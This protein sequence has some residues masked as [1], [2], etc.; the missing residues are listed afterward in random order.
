MAI[1]SLGRTPSQ[2]P[3]AA[4]VLFAAEWWKQE[5]EG[6]AWDW[7]PIFKKLSVDADSFPPQLRSEFVARGLSFWQLR[8]LADGKRFI[9]SIAVNGGIPMRL[10]AHGSGP[11]ATVLSQLLKL[12][13]RYRWGP[14]QLLEAATERQIYLPAAYRRAEISELLVQFVEAVL[15]LKEE[16]LL[17]GLS[18]PTA[19][20]DSV[21]PNWR[22]RF[23]IAL[24]SEAAQTLLTGLVREAAAQGSGSARGLFHAERRLLRAGDTTCH[25]IESHVSH[26]SRAAVEDIAGMFGFG[27]TERL[28]RYFSIDLETERRQPCTDG[29]I[30][31]GAEESI[32]SLTAGKLVVKGKAALAEHLL[33]LRGQKGDLGDR[34]T[35]PGGSSLPDE[36]PWLFV[37]GEAGHL[38]FAA[39]GGA[40][41]PHD[42]AWVALPV[43][44]S[45][46][47][48]DPSTAED[49]GELVCT[50]V[51]VRK[52]F[53]L[54]ADTRLRL[55]ELQ[56]RVRL[57]QVS[58]ADQIYQWKGV[59][60]PEARGRSVF[61]DRQYPRLYRCGETALSQVPLSDQEWRRRGTQDVVA[62][63]EATGPVEVRVFDGD[64]LCARH[65]IF[66]LRPDAQIEYLSG[67]TLGTGAV[68]FI[69]WGPIELAIEPH[70]GFCAEVSKSGSAATEIELS[71]AGEPPSE[72]RVRIRWPG[73]VGELL[74]V[75]PY[76]VTGG[77]FLRASGQV[78][79]PDESVSLRDLIGMRL[80][81]F[82]TNPARPNRY[83]LQLSHGKGGRKV[84]SQ[85]PIS[86]DAGGRAEVRL[87]DYQRQIES[88]LGLFD[89]LDATVTASLMVAGHCTTE[90]QVRRYAAT[91]EKDAN[92]VRVS[93]STLALLAPADLART[94]VVASPLAVQ[95]ELL[96]ELPS[97]DS[98][99][100]HVGAWSTCELDPSLAPWL[101]YPA[102]DSAVLFRP[103]VWAA[104]VD[105]EIEAIAGNSPITVDEL[106]SAMS[107]PDAYERWSRLHTVL[108]SMS[109]EFQHA[110]WPQLDSLWQT[111]H[112][113]PLPALD[114]WR[115]LAKQPKAVLSFLLRS[116]LPDAELAEALR[117]F[118][119]ETGWVPELT[120]VA[121]LCEVAGT[122][123]KFWSDQGLAADRCRK[124]FNDELTD[125][126]SLLAHEI[127]SLEPFLDSVVFAATGTAS[128]LLLETARL[129]TVDLLRRLWEGGDSLVNAQLFLVNFD[130]SEWPGRDFV[131]RQALPALLE[132]CPDSLTGTLLKHMDKL[133]WNFGA[134]RAYYARD[135]SSSAQPDFKFSAANLPVLCALWSATSTSR[136][137]WGDPHQ[138]LV[139][140]QIRD[141]D[142]VW[143]EQAYHHACKVLMSIDGLV[144]LGRITDQ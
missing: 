41:L 104:P 107:E 100:V 6:G 85:F 128:T 137:W 113:L 46:E 84:S 121:D 43:D 90:I 127:P 125:R 110:S 76:P 1:R 57:K 141:F 28:P 67:E 95:G 99:S 53:R 45:I 35:V 69:N 21:L 82:D 114:V 102:E 40:R 29:R 120:T 71:S 27:D 10:L 131:E 12:A 98:Q 15:L 133:F 62:P 11:L 8:P 138:R 48:E 3:P 111:F 17:D 7:S 58:Q 49:V 56:Y 47:T 79:Q 59:R 66:V 65:R 34:V 52:V 22:R 30:A 72:F 73:S 115:M 23:P 24:E 126:F 39:A 42:E 94:R 78:M 144:Q 4:F 118:R 16:Y 105:P 13:A 61:R 18:D 93:D 51:S 129:K 132:S 33:V 116:E 25:S 9:G 101:I 63:K 64:E 106:G 86:L 68:R 140:R 26:A 89:D 80:Q 142:P 77:R 135:F 32:A 81:V 123:W 55:D 124:H 37:E 130:R 97:N 2:A 60:L 5:Y 143:F 103:L 38:L 50:G 31:L 54:R 87:L 139:L 83:A 134:W 92:T 109:E 14:A 117:R 19:K 74:L 119:N 108:A 70:S 91:L 75:L 122:F 112:H 88:L 136:Q 20:L 44:W 96:R 36:D